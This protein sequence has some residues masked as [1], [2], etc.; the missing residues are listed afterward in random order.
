[1]FSKRIIKDDDLAPYCMPFF[2]CEDL[3]SVQEQ[4]DSSDSSTDSIAE[5]NQP[6]IEKNIQQHIEQIE[7]DAYERG[8]IAGEKAGFEI[9]E[10]KASVLLKKLE[11]ILRELSFIKEKILK[12]LEPQIFDFAVSL[13][14]RIIIEEVSLRPDIIVSIIK[15][16]LK[17]IEKTGTIKIRVSPSIHS[18]ILK[19]KPELLSI[20]PDIIFDVDHSITAPIIT[21]PEQEIITDIDE[22]IKNILEDIRNG[23]R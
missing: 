15:E 4:K 5:G 13:A 23:L 22:Q 9:G 16:A 10:Q 12:D 8:F 14:K 7:K 11:D 2:E 19:V 17:K 6:A 3:D 21:G 1:M 18:I 20:H